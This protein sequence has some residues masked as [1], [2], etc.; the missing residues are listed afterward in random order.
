MTSAAPLTRRTDLLRDQLAHLPHGTRRL[1]GASPPVRVGIAGSGPELLVL[2]WSAAELARERAAGARLLGCLGIRAGMR[3]GNTLAGA[4]ATPGALLLGDVVED[5]GALDVPLGALDGDAAA[6]QAWEL[7]DRVQPAVLVLE[8]ATAPRLFAA[9]PAGEQ[10]WWH[11]I[12]W[13]RRGVAGGPATPPP[14]GFTGWQRTWLAVPEAT[15]FV[16]GSCVRGAFH[17]DEAVLAEV[18]A[19]AT[20]A[21][22]GPGG[23]GILALTVPGGDAPLLRFASGVRARVQAAACPCG[24]RGP[25]L[26][27]P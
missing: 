6:R 1:A 3:V 11:G 17:V 14:A 27:L 23:D 9:A 2:A 12:V 10:P 22:V 13:L 19:E 7:A 18:V 5:M 20:G 26:E 8:E 4:L 21:P 16:A 15:S 25:A 24:A